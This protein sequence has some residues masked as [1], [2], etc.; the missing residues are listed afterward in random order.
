MKTIRKI[1]AL[2]L[3][4]LFQLICLLVSPVILVMVTF[5]DIFFYEPAQTPRQWLYNLVSS[6]FAP[7]ILW[8]RI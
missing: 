6:L 4:I 2:P 1:V 3:A 7:V 5:S 8:W